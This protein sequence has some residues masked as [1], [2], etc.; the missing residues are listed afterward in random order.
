MQKQD[1][2]NFKGENSMNKHRRKRS[3]KKIAAGITAMV[4][5]VALL[6]G[7]TLAWTDFLQHKDN[8]MRGMSDT[9]VTLNDEF[10]PDNA[11][12]NST[13]A[14]KKV[15]VTNPK[16]SE[17]NVFIKVQF[18]EFLETYSATY[19]PIKDSDGEKVY[20]A[21]WANG[22]KIG[23]YLTSDEALGQGLKYD[24]FEVGGVEYAR[25]NF[26]ENRNGIYGKVMYDPASR[27]NSSVTDTFG[28]VEKATKQTHEQVDSRE[29][30]ESYACDYETY[31]WDGKGIESRANTG[32]FVHELYFKWNQGGGV[33]TMAQWNAA[34]QPLGNFWII[35]ADGWCYW[36]MPLEPGKTT[37]NILESLTMLGKPAGDYEY[38]IHVDMKSTDLADI[39]LLKTGT[40]SDLI[41][42]LS[43]PFADIYID[44][45]DGTVSE[46]VVE[47]GVFKEIITIVGPDGVPGTADD[48]SIIN[49]AGDIILDG[50]TAKK[51]GEGVYVDLGNDFKLRPGDDGKIGTKDDTVTF[52][53]YYQQ[54][55]TTKTALEWNLLDVQNNQA[56]LTTKYVHGPVKYT[57]SGTSTDYATS[58]L[59]KWLNGE[60]GAD[61][62]LAVPFYSNAF[63]ASDKAK[64]V[65]TLVK[66]PAEKIIAFTD[67]VNHES[68]VFNIEA[69]N[70]L[71]DNVFVLTNTELT[72]YFGKWEWAE[73]VDRTYSYAY[74][75]PYGESL[76]MYTNATSKYANYIPRTQSTANNPNYMFFIDAGGS[77]R[78]H[79]GI[80]SALRGARPAIT[81]SLG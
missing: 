65:P 27:D 81:V 80:L 30:G 76:G 16:D 57:T 2:E 14:S 51:D 7:G 13:I 50:V 43:V 71:T 54:N 53:E 68:K 70:D 64:I 73:N 60:S 77:I 74:A 4:L 26:T 42:K 62:S 63:S 78:S 33:V 61:A 8:P 55:A 58:N 28:S 32:D 9:E 12:K 18:K 59:R 3:G 75:T 5:V 52:G 79:G 72:K 15:S 40:S 10:I 46:K 24:V 47:D 21:T 36:A 67:N 23:E 1:L 17:N 6:L 66:T 38:V 25:I 69:K 56:L 41:D 34:G 37:G 20:F 29:P 22:S 35:D 11:F 44:N 19:E 31:L 39:N 48:N 45:G 49:P